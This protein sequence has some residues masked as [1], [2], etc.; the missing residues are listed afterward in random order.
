MTRRLRIPGLVDLVRIDDPAMIAA[1][2]ADPRLDRDFTGKGPLIN[3]WIVGRIRRNL[4]TPNAPLPSALPRNYPGRVEQQ[5]ALQSRLENLVA[6]GSVGSEHVAELAAHVRGE[7][8]DKTL[9]PL[10]QETIGRLFVKDYRAT[11]E[12]WRAACVLAAAPRNV[13]PLRALYWALTG[14]V[15]RARRVLSEAAGGD[16]AGVHATTVA[17]HTLVRNLEA[18]RELW[19][20]PGARERMS[21]ETAVIRSLRAPESVPRRWSKAASTVWGNLPEGALTLFELDAARARDPDADTVFLAASWSHCPAAGW[22]TAL[23]KA[24]WQRAA[25]GGSTA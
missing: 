25:S 9:G 22:T 7:R 13:N 4:R 23:L 16:T 21:A 12:T 20:Q 18:M 6:Q 17:V 14:A 2:S 24:V 19:S 10:V 5:A 11:S 15:G 8:G 1:A 3:R